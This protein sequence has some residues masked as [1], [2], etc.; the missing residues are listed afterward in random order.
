MHGNLWEEFKACVKDEFILN[1]SN[2]CQGA[3]FVTL[4]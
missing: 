4:C 1:N 2:E 3:T